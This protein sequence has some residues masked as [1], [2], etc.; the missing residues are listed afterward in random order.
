MKCEFVERAICTG[1][2]KT[3]FTIP[4]TN[5][6]IITQFKARFKGTSGKEYSIRCGPLPYEKWMGSYILALPMPKD[7]PVNII[8]IPNGIT[9]STDLDGRFCQECG[10]MGFSGNLTGGGTDIFT[11]PECNGL[12]YIGNENGSSRTE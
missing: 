9:F 5:P 3:T 1:I 8:S 11:C 10:A 4:G 6:K 7:C 2:D 12:C